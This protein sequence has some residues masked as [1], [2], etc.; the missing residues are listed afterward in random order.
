MIEGNEKHV[1]M[2]VMAEQLVWLDILGVG[3]SEMAGLFD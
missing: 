3:N 2:V 1:R